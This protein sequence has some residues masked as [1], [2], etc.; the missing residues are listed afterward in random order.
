MA[1]SMDK[2]FLNGDVARYHRAENIS[3]DLKRNVVSFKL[4]CYR[5]FGQRAYLMA[6]VTYMKMQCPWTDTDVQQLTAFVYN[7]I[8]TL[9]EWAN[10][11]DA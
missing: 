7:Y 1:L 10:A 8:K 11:Q 5:D 6:P 2:T 3:L 4:C 9:P